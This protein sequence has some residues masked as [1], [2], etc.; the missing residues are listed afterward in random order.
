[1]R[2]IIGQIWRRGGKALL[3]TSLLRF[4]AVGAITT[5]MDLL[6]FAT[7]ARGLGIP[8]IPA[9]VVSYSCGVATSFVLNRYWTFSNNSREGLERHALR[10]V[11][12]NAAGLALSCLLVA[13]LVHLMPEVTA[14]VLSVPMVFVWNYVVARRWVFT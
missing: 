7:L 9:N 12:S 14:K 3:H 2:H 10:F 13:V 11:A 8:A 5:T 1:M 4:A 6:L